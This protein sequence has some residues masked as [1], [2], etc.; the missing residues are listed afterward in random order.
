MHLVWGIVPNN[1]DTRQPFILACCNLP[2]PVADGGGENEKGRKKARDLR[3]NGC[4]LDL[5]RAMTWW[6]FFRV[7][8]AS[9]F[10]LFFLLLCIWSCSRCP[11]CLAL[12]RVLVKGGSVDRQGPSRSSV[13]GG[14]EGS[15]VG[16]CET[17][18]VGRKDPC[19]RFFLLFFSSVKST[20]GP[21]S[22]SSCDL[23][24]YH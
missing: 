17:G 22:A 8:G 5:S 4:N 9:F 14:A 19:S 20:R 7:N 16:T 3:V 1:T 13:E 24:L 15:M 6:K 12:S 10:G 2:R 21:S 18:Q 11:K 23:C